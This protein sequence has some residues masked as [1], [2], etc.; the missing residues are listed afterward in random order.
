MAA[1]KLRV[2]RRVETATLDTW[3]RVFSAPSPALEEVGELVEEHVLLSASARRDP[4]GKAWRK[5]KPSTIA[6]KAKRDKRAN[7]LGTGFTRKV[8]ERRVGVGFASPIARIQHSGIR[9]NRLFGRR[10]SGEGMSGPRL[11]S[12]AFTRGEIKPVPARPLLPLKRKKV[13]LPPALQEQL[14]IVLARS[15]R[16]MV[17]R[18]RR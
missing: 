9:Q 6:I 8:T 16:S 18:M 17:A 2:T 12:G 3:A 7:I 10:G 14:S 15:F 5:L 13:R 1:V 4:W 11:R